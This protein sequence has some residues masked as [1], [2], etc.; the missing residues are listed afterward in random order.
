MR[1]ESQEPAWPDPAPAAPA[2]PAAPTAPA[3]RTTIVICAYTLDRWADLDRAVRSALRQSAPASEVILVVDHHADLARRAR[4]TWPG[5]RV[6][7]SRGPRGLSGARNTGVDEASGDIV[8]FLDDDAEAD[9][10]WLAELVAPYADDRVVATGG[11]AEAAWDTGRP[12]WFPPEFDWVVGCSYVGLPRTRAVVRNPIGSTMSLRR[13]PVLEA[14]GFSSE[15]GR[16]GTTPTGGEETE[17]C[18]RI[19]R[20]RPGSQVVLV[21]TARVRHRVPAARATFRYFRSRCFQEGRSK[22]RIA[23]L[24]GAGA[25][26]ASE[27]AYS[28][29]TL[30]AAVARGVRDA[31]R[32]QG[33]G[34]GRA[35]AV[36]AGLA[37]TTAG[38]LAGR[39]EAARPVATSADLERGQA[40]DPRHEGAARGIRPGEPG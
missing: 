19:Q 16:I 37:L 34:L 4:G 2:A 8:A 31:L 5:V 32:G 28:T 25:A 7:E 38:Y 18:I 35:A 12:S 14:G 10:N 13:G 1:S 6:A 23:M 20:L 21:P 11:H 22:A 26:L 3:A 30:P 39:I 36:L 27:R 40:G 9:F 17:L 24:E 15:V 33:S 29:R